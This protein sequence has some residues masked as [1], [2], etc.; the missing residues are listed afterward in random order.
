MA[1]PLRP[2]HVAHHLAAVR[3][4]FTGAASD[5]AGLCRKLSLVGHVAGFVGDF[6]GHRVALGLFFAPAQDRR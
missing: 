5:E 6:Q 4:F 3:N 1:G 2:L